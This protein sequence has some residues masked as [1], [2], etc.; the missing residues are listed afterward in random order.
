MQSVI[1]S[2]NLVKD[3]TQVLDS[4]KFDKLFILTDK[5]THQLCLGHLTKIEEK[6]PFKVFTIEAGDD[7]KNLDS[8]SSIWSFLVNNRA[9]RHSLLINLGG[10]M[11][12]DIGGFAA[13]TFKRGIKCINIPTTLLGA[14]DAAVGGKTGI[15]FEGL[16]NEIGNFSNPY[17]VIIDSIFFKTLNQQNLLSGYAEMIKHSLLDND[18]K[19]NEIINF[20]LKNIDYTALRDLTV[21]S[22][23]L[24]EKVVTEDPHEKGIRKALNLGHTIGHAFES[25]SYEIKKPIP[26]GYAIAWGCIAE[27]YLSN[28][29]CGFPIEKLRITAQY[30]KEYY[31]GFPFGCE[32]YDKLYDL[33]K[34]DKKNIGDE[35]NFTLLEDI[36]M[37]KIDQTA[38]K[39]KILNSIDF[40]RDCIGV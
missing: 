33:M 21:S 40:L 38:H 8:L 15:N 20:D 34:H 23:E 5:N 22:V 25:L 17:V 32:H 31:H 3:L 27:L 19:W 39:E 28:I 10:G 1:K 9:T 29:Q 37:V 18:K 2:T 35:I 24:K 12:T 30:I 16:K 36:G 6:F 4:M 26:H 7:S 13:A 11:I 14:V